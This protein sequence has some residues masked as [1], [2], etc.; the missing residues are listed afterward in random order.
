LNK[1]KFKERS[2]RLTKEKEEY[3]MF[4]GRK[5]RRMKV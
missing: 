2:W 1:E 3:L 4:R 5:R